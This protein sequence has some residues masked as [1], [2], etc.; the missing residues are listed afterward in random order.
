[1]S[2]KMPKIVL[3]FKKIA[4]DNFLKQM[5]SFWQFFDIQLPIFQRVSSA[6]NHGTK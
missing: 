3:F 2:E 1:M 6:L 5:L 4:K